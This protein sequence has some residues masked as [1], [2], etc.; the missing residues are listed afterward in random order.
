MGVLQAKKRLRSQPTQMTL[1]D[2]MGL[3]LTKW[4][5]SPGNMNW[6]DADAV[7]NVLAWRAIDTGKPHYLE[8]LNEHCR[9]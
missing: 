8:I 1:H 3:I 9:L 6:G 2:V 7:F 5:N 4:A